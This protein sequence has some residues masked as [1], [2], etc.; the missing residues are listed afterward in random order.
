MSGER[1]FCTFYLDGQYF[2]IDVHNVLEVLRYQP[3]TRVPLAPPEVAGLINL[4]G[5]IVT[6]IDLR[7]RLGLPQRG[8]DKPPMNIMVATDEGA[9][10]L[11]VDEIGGVLNVSEN[12]FEDAPGT[13]AGIARGLIEGI[14]KLPD[15]LLLV[16]S[17][18]K[19]VDS[20]GSG[21]MGE[22]L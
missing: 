7:S 20:I 11:L 18:D 12:D 17:P 5:Q 19:S 9:V 14:Y 15:K 1:Q 16:L 6:A 2:G 4:R 21:L 10:S 13:V 8:A 22:Q 3:I